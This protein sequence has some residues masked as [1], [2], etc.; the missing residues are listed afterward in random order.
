MMPP[1]NN[2][3]QRINVR[4]NH[5]VNYFSSSSAFAVSI[6]DTAHSNYVYM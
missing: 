3:E 5:C 6:G 2:P 1:T 4:Q